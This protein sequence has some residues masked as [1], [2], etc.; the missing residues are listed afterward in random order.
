MRRWGAAGLWVLFTTVAVTSGLLAVALVSRAVTS[1]NGPI[2]SASDVDAKLAAASSTPSSDVLATPS[3]TRSQGLSGG[4]KP[5]RTAEPSKK[6]DGQPSTSPSSQ[7]SG[8][9]SGGSKPSKTSKQVTTVRTI[10]SRGGTVVAECTAGQ[11]YLRSWSPAS[12]YHTDEVD[13]G[14]DSEAEIRFD[15]ESTEVKVDI[16]CSG[17]VAVGSQEVSSDSSDD[18]SNGGSDDKSD[19]KDE[20]DD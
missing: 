9:P 6:P 20:D 18:G 10:S 11:V 4:P 12:G 3:P 15:S 2:L 1:S 16:R 17:G 14:P 8:Q 13:R 7:P 19:S 5:S